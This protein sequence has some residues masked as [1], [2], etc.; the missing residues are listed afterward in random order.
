MKITSMV[1]C[2]ILLFATSGW[3][4]QFDSDVPAA[5]RE[6]MLSDLDF[7]GQ[8]EAPKQTPLHQRVFGELNGSAY[9][10]FFESR[11]AGVGL[12][13]CGSPN[14]VA[15]VIPYYDS[16]RIW[17]TN[18]YIRFS[19]PQIARLMVIYHEAR[20]TERSNRFWSHASCPRPFLDEQGRE[21]K[22][23]WTGAPLAGEAACDVTPFGSYG[24]STIML[25][26]VAKF[27][28]NCSS[29][30]KMDADLYATDQLGRITNTRARQ[31]MLTDFD[32]E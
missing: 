16:T 29:K 30:V 20:H 2:L 18:N 21:K 7:V 15:C 11:V 22:S 23:I 31:Q 32:F 6:Q 27:C 24:S 3:A 1:G 14:A 4:L 5:I 10:N 17:L 19:H 26:N 28:S 25:K 8:I 9:R 13:D 12:D